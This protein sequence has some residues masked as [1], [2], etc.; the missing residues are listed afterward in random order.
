M[1]ELADLL[2]GETTERMEKSLLALI[3]EFNAVRTGRANIGILDNLNVNYYGVATPIKQISS[4]SIQEG[5]ILYLK[6]YDKGILRAIEAAINASNIGL[7][8][9]NDGTGIRLIFPPI[10]EE[11]RR[12]LVKEVEGISEN[13]KI[14]IRNIRR[15]ANDEIKK[16]ELTEDS[17]K[18]YLADIQKLTDDYIK[19][20]TEQAEHKATELMKK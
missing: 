6:P 1:D 2:I 12:Q 11:R 15:S 14:A 13:G 4:I 8:P 7:P 5:T 17:E 20:I 19:K 16:M 10:T 9:Q 18:G 3:S